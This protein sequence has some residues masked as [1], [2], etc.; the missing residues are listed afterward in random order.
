MSRIRIISLILSPLLAILKTEVKVPPLLT[1]LRGF[2]HTHYVQILSMPPRSCVISPKPHFLTHMFFFPFTPC[3]AKHAH[4]CLGHLNLPIHM[5][6][7]IPSLR[8]AHL[9]SSITFSE[10]ETSCYTTLQEYSTIA[11]YPLALFY[12]EGDGTP[13][14]YSCLANP[15]DG[16]AW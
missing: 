10:M 7:Q 15:M 9:Y 11:F 16:E 5:Q 12:R 6:D 1:I 8:A 4:P 14:Q 13:L 2:H 3:V